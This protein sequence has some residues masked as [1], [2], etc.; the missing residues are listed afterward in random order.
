MCSSDEPRLDQRPKRQKKQQGVQPAAS[1]AYVVKFRKAEL[2]NRK[3]IA[4]ANLCALNQHYLP[5]LSNKTRPVTGF[6]NRRCSNTVRRKRFFWITFVYKR[7]VHPSNLTMRQVN[8]HTPSKARKS[9]ST[10]A[11]YFLTQSH[12]LVLQQ[13]KDSMIFL[14][15]HTKHALSLSLSN[16]EMVREFKRQLKNDAK[17]NQ[18]TF[19]TNIVRDSTSSG[20]WN[21][22]YNTTGC[23]V[24]V[25]FII[26]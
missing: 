1:T 20:P 14:F 16:C 5:G 2:I 21:P 4:C 7:R 6:F 3:R 26:E 11:E 9:R 8:A 19:D 10:S 12:T 22:E 25:I 18:C 17:S 13:T 23:T 24:V 15:K